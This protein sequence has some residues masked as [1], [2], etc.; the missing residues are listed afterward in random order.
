[1]ILHRE[2]LPETDPA[3]RSRADRIKE[4]EF[5]ILDARADVR[6]EREVVGP[7]VCDRKRGQDNDAGRD[8]AES[9]HSVIVS[10]YA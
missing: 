7:G 9:A 4:R 2:S 6:L 5:V 8:V 3:R 1:M 10:V